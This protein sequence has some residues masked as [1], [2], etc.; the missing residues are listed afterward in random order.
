MAAISGPPCSCRILKFS[1]TEQLGQHQSTGVSLS[2]TT[3]SSKPLSRPGALNDSITILSQFLII[4]ITTTPHQHY[5]VY[6][7]R[8]KDLLTLESY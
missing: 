3:L 7:V 4:S 2:L 5:N 6:F 1:D 8:S